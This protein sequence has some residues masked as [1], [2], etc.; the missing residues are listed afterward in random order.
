M[1]FMEPRM[2]TSFSVYSPNIAETKV[3]EGSGSYREEP[4]VEESSKVDEKRRGGAKVASLLLVNQ[5]LATLAFFGVGVNLVL[6]LSRVLGQ[7]NAHAANNVSKW[8]GTVYMFSLIGAFLSDSY[9]GRFLTCTIFQLI[10]VL[11]L[12]LSS[13]SSWWFLIKPSGCGDGNSPCMP[14]PSFGVSIFYLSIYLV[15]FGYGGHQ[16]TLATFGADQYDEKNPK[17]KNSKVAFFCYFYFALNVGSLFSNTVLVY[18]E[19]SGKWTLGFLVSLASAVIAF[20]SFLAGTP[21]YRHVKPCG[22]PVMRVAQVFMA[23]A[24][25]WG[26]TPANLEELFEVDGSESAIKGSRKIIHS[27]DFKF[28]DKAATITLK[29]KQS[30]NNP[31]RLCTVTQVEESK[32][33]LRM[34]PVWLCTI[35]YSVVFTQMASLFVEQGRLSGNQKG[36]TELQRMGIGLIIGMLAMVASGA[37]EI[38]R[39]R[40]IIPGQKSSS[41]SIFWQIPQYILVGASEVFMY[42]GQLEFFNGQAPDGI[43]S[44]GSSL[45]MASIS[46]GNYVSSMLVNMVMG[47]TARGQSQ[48]WIP[49]NL[50]TGHIDRFFFLLAGLTAFD[51][52]LYLFCAKW[53]KSIKFGDNGDIG[54]QEDDGVNSKV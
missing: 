52:V 42:V 17:E 20:L 38:L 4:L 27:D 26:V 47:I 37:T 9:W 53:Y 25:K 35:I 7:D 13:F 23:A 40:H 39:L 16:P 41:L 28:M 49:D 33:V 31:W 45:C 46:L 51:F 34:L 54:M 18:Y 48:G 8:T 32:C 30:R 3:M 24:R 12:A 5:A 21:R 29:D 2:A 1:C 14:A 11:G 36:L 22:N 10:F 50:N 15:A 19:D 6:F 43:K 44:F